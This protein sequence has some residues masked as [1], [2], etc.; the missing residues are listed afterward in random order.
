MAF[1]FDLDNVPSIA[2]LSNDTP[3]SQ[4]GTASDN[5]EAYHTSANVDLGETRSSSMTEKDLGNDYSVKNLAQHDGFVS[6]ANNYLNGRY[7]ASREKGETNEDVVEEYLTHYR[8]M[9][10]NTVDLMQEVDFLREA[11]KQTKDDFQILYNVYQDTPNFLSEGGGGVMSGVADIVGSVLTDPATVV[12]MGFGGPIGSIL[13]QAA[14]QAGKG[15]TTRMVLKTALKG[16]LGKIGGMTSVEGLLGSMH[17]SQRQE[18][19]IEADMMGKKDVGDIVTAGA[20]T[21]GLS[22]IGYPLA[23]RGLASTVGKAIPHSRLDRIAAIK[24]ESSGAPKA[25]LTRE[26]TLESLAP[27]EI[28]KFDPEVAIGIRNRISPGTDLLD[29]KTTLQITKLT[30]R[31][32]IDM[33]S[34]MMASLKPELRDKF[35]RQKGEKISDLIYRT[36]LQANTIDDEIVER[37]ITKQGITVAEFGE[38]HRLTA[39]EAGQTLRS[40]R[41]MGAKIE[42]MAADDPDLKKKLDELY[43]KPSDSR[44]AV[45]TVYDLLRRADRETR[46][47]MVTQVA[48]TAR[49]VLSG[50]AYLTFGAAA[51]ALEGTIYGVGKSIQSIGRGTASIQGTTEGTTKIVKD[52]ASTLISVMNSKDSQALANAMLENTPKLHG[53]L[54][55]SLQETG[56]ET[57]SKFTRSM[58]GLNMAQDVVLRSGVFTDSVNTRMM[59]V[60]LDMEEYIAKNKDIPMEILKSAIDDSLEAT[61]AR[62]PSS[63]LLKAFVQGVE[64]MPFLPIIGTFTFPFARFTA[65]A[66]AFQASYSPANFFS[67]MG[68]GYR[69]TKQ[70][71][72][73]KNTP[74][75]ELKRSLLRQSETSMEETVQRL[76]KGAVG[77]SVLYGAMMYREEHPELKW[78]E[79]M[80]EGKPVDIRAIFP[81]SPYLAIAD[82]IT[83]LNNK[84][85]DEVFSQIMEGVTGSQMKAGSVS[86][87]VGDFFEALRDLDSS[88]VSSEK[89]G[90][91]F[92]NWT[93]AITGRI[94]TPAAV[95]RDAF[96]VFDS[97]E[98]I[99]R[100]TRIAEGDT[101]TD[102][103]ISAFTNNLKAKMPVL[104]KDLPEYQSP[105]KEGATYRQS[106]FATQL[107]GMK[108]SEHRSFVETEFAKHG[109]ETYR[110]FSSTGSKQSDYLVNK[111]AP[112]YVNTMIGAV[113]STPWYKSLPKSSQRVVL[114][115]R[116]QSARKMIK[117]VA[118]GEAIM[119]AYRKG[120]TF[121]VFD[122][123]NWSKL[124]TAQRRLADEY[125]KMYYGGSVDELGSYKAAITIGRAL[126]RAL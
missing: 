115:K 72:E 113:I 101:G 49:N 81:M 92:G 47:M 8:Y 28:G 33:H 18:M 5:L 120:K 87:S 105:T 100:S 80:Q 94:L 15:A 118:E 89:V 99:V 38:L 55:R 1:E 41:G 66:L 14:K 95:V 112:P 23:A 46:A 10:N 124:P 4:L 59:K 51:K 85:P 39:R 84:A 16:N 42:Q 64:R 56:N 53:T 123:A 79:V 63:P 11:D 24:S 91:M 7:G 22:L 110:L 35:A 68:S 126:E 50:A 75:G 121:T 86:G 103:F 3:R 69:W 60:G 61:F 114:K 88:D 76:S 71:R 67:A 48:T 93:G 44:T 70:A 111:H 32:A 30:N 107:T 43:G 97:S 45:G 96:A 104:Q 122:K 117:E 27:S 34:N 37:A 65:D 36:I 73:A 54:F 6:K 9:S 13:A 26:D 62:T 31:V 83:N 106:P 82:I 109:L 20:L 29:T 21:G 74:E 78:Y 102:K 58:N 116:L 12:G 125:F 19:L 108:P 90:E 25:P 2:E 57:L 119:Q 17:E 52:A 98:A 77:S 40:F